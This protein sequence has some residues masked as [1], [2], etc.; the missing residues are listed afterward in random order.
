MEQ[1]NESGK[2]KA[3]PAARRIAKELG[4][5]LEKIAGTGIDGRIQ[6]EDVQSYHETIGQTSASRQ[7][8]PEDDVY[9]IVRPK[10]EKTIADDADDTV[11]LTEASAQTVQTP[12]VFEETTTFINPAEPVCEDHT[13]EALMLDDAEDEDEDTSCEYC[14]DED[15]DDYESDDDFDL[16][17]PM[18]VSISLEVNDEG[19][20]SMLGGM[21][22]EL[23]DELINAVVKTVCCA[24][25]KAEIFAYEDRINVLE[26][27]G[28]DVYA[29]TAINAHESKI[30]EIE[31][32]D[33]EF[34]DVLINIWDLTDTGLK[35]F[36]KADVDTMNL[37]VLYDDSTI[38]VEMTCDEY[39]LD[40]GEC[41][42][43]MQLLKKFLQHPSYMLL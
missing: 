13:E 28:K 36:Q 37:F 14:E 18:P 43:F 20:I 35:S 27:E 24:L 38:T 21:Q 6:L 30:S 19:I 3:S 34:D 2:V 10:E 16:I 40:V 29:R 17:P 11:L 42:Y 22:S 32:T 39:L 23:D 4:L 41:A 1:H 26:L 9:E 5:D 31:Y 15:E 33:E 12:A 8:V 25:K 7:S